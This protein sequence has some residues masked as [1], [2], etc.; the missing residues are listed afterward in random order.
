MHHFATRDGLLHV[1]EVSL[2]LIARMSARRSTGYST[3]TF[4]RHYRVFDQAFAGTDHAIFY[5]AKANSIQAVMK[6]LVDLGAGIDV[7]SEVNCGAFG[8]GV[9]GRKIVFSGIGKTAREMAAAS[10]NASPASTSSPNPSS[11]CFPTSQC[12]LALAPPYR[13]GSIRISMPQTHEKIA[14]GRAGTSRHV[15]PAPMSIPGSC[16]SSEHRLGRVDMPNL[17]SPSRGDFSWV[18]ASISGLTRIDMVASAKAHCDVGKTL[19]LGSDRR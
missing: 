8:L 4:E 2:R 13:F 14:T 17:F 7:V 18:W 12:A 15:D 10:R 11:S 5:S 6:T 19:E 1:E 9:P 16:G 3:A